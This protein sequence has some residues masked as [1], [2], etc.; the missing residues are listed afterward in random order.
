MDLKV[1]LVDISTGRK[2]VLLNNSDALHIGVRPHDRI[3][4][5]TSKKELT[6]IVN[7]TDSYVNQGEIGITPSLKKFFNCNSGETMEITTTGR[8][9]SMDYIHKK[10]KGENLN[11]K[12][13]H[14]IIG[15]IVEGNL[16]ELEIAAFVLSQQF[17]GMSLDEI[18]HLTRSMVETG[19]K[20]DF[21]EP[22]FDKHSVGGVPGNK[23]SLLI[24]PIVA[25]A[26][27][28]IPKTS[29]KAITSPSGTADTM[30]VLAPVS[31]KAD[32]LQE[33]VKKTR[34]ALVWGGALN[35]APA[36]DLII[37]V[38]HP[39]RIDPVSQMIASII[40]K[41]YSVGVDNMVLDIPV[42]PGTKM[43]N[44]EEGENFAN[45]FV[46]IGKRLKIASYCGLT[47][48]GQPVGHAVGPALE[49]KEALE[50]LMGGGPT[51]LIEKST[52]L[53]GF[54]LEL[55][56]VA[57]ENKGQDY[58]K[59]ILR[60][61]KA[62]KKMQEI[63]EAQGGDSKVKPE[64]ISIGEHVAGVEA[65]ADGYVTQVNNKNITRIAQ[66]AGAPLDKGAGVILNYKIGYK[67]SK[68][69]KLLSIYAE[70]ESKLREATVIAT[71]SYPIIVEGMLL[72][73]LPKFG[74]KIS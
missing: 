16:S 44:M 35:L 10:M 53:A 60:S 15:D 72:Q 32:E 65:K 33:L 3:K 47:Y 14:A 61:G 42:G 46:E 8:S 57:P 59:E 24:V 12:E 40:A 25:A 74:G 2:V 43:E 37:Q 50:A 34:G 23:V 45:T 68:G 52:A 20:I 11:Y 49:A 29:S 26:G 55:G 17:V 39:L 67:V 28:L 5:K 51:S 73:K 31:F 70:K 6:V 41:K 64:D 62:L 9:S 18:E 69:D 30:E 13:I 19:E 56:G 54:L 58:A 36:D 21:D 7:I 63:I 22:A 71:R 27:L 1:K 66:A 38:E 48:G 4:V